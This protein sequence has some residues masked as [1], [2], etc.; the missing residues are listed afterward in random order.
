MKIKD[1]LNDDT[2]SLDDKLIGTDA[3]DSDN[4]KS[5]TIEGLIDFIASNID[6]G[7]SGTFI[8]NDD[9]TITVVNGVIVS[10]EEN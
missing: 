7:A 1:Y 9:K 3:Q 6:L 8:S 10:I 2:I 5:Y 4:T